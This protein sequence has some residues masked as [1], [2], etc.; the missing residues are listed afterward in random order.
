VQPFT[1]SKAVRKYRSNYSHFD[2]TEI[3]SH[4][5]KAHSAVVIPIRKE[6]VKTVHDCLFHLDNAAAYK[7]ISCCSILV[8]NGP[9][10]ERHIHR[11]FISFIDAESSRKKFPSLQ[12]VI[13]DRSTEGRWFGP[14]DGVGLARKI[15][16][17]FAFEHIVRARVSSP[18]VR[19]LD[20]D[21]FV[22]CDYF[23]EFQ[24]RTG[25]Y[26]YEF[27]HDTSQLDATHAEALKIYDQYLRYYQRGL[28]AAGSPFNFLAFGSN[29]AIHAETYAE[30][31][32]FPQLQA[33]EDFYLMNKVA[34]MKQVYGARDRE[35]LRI[36]GRLSD[37]VPFGTGP[38]IMKYVREIENGG[39]I[40]FPHPALF[41]TLKTFLENL[42]SLAEARP[43]LI[44]EIFDGLR[45][46]QFLTD[47]ELS[48]H[49]A[50]PYQEALNLASELWESTPL[51][52]PAI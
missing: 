36:I 23:Q 30:V 11:E 4:F 34:K 13:L 37:R 43:S 12:L 29:I 6:S 21:T 18:W 38:A 24:N 20:A 28:T 22:P 41:L 31:R 7:K 32:G 45:T 5:D 16:F 3:A 17:D 2:E 25:M 40:L 27:L 44:P 48:H 33:G 46:R 52:S 15:G 35:A 19:S 49:P 14:K 39:R 50:I 10:E 51:M 9:E 47:A 1:N 26:L 42:E 8:V